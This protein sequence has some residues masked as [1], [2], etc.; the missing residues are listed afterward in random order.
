MS[1]VFRAYGKSSRKYVAV[2]T[3]PL[4]STTPIAA[5]LSG[6]GVDV[7]LGVGD[8]VGGAATVGAALVETATGSGPPNEQPPSSPNATAA[9]MATPT[10]RED[11]A[12][13]T[14]RL[15]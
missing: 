1:P 3:A 12:S 2:A 13:G 9:A 11:L 7:G 10:G 4:T 6:L 5:G 15:R 8:G 14:S